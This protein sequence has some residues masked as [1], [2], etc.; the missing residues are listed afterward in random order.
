M[1][2]GGGRLGARTLVSSHVAVTRV[3]DGG[4]MGHV[5]AVDVVRKS[6]FGYMGHGLRVISILRPRAQA[7]AEDFLL[8]CV[9]IFVSEDFLLRT[10]E[11]HLAHSALPGPSPKGPLSV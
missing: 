10:R 2:G 6:G 4:G 8:P 5:V 1:V 3:R 9:Y 11:G 7:A